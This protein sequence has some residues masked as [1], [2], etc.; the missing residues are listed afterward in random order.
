MS[1]RVE[2]VRNRQYDRYG[3]EV[4]NS[5][6]PY[7]I[8]LSKSPLTNTQ[9]STLQRLAIKKSWSNRTQIK[10]IRLARTI[11]DL[12]SSPTITDQSIWEA[13]EFNEV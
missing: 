2:E 6:I 5:R 3:M 9:N 11:S 4:C 8:L 12:Q 1:E 13:I 7:E 10:I